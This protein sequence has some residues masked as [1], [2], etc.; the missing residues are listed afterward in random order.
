MPTLRFSHKLLEAGLHPRNL[1]SVRSTLILSFSLH[2]GVTSDPFPLDFHC[3]QLSGHSTLYPLID[4]AKL[5]GVFWQHLVANIS[6]L[7]SSVF[8]IIFHRRYLHLY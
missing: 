3:G 1:S 2:L 7:S 6:E 4:V 5:M 8:F